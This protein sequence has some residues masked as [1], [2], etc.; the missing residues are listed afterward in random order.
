MSKRHPQAVYDLARELHAKGMSVQ[1]IAFQVPLTIPQ[2][3]R[4]VDPE[5]S[6]QQ[7]AYYAKR[8]AIRR[9]ASK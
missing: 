1:A 5:Y 7:S 4:A 3:K 9:N 2:I 8:Q 6:K